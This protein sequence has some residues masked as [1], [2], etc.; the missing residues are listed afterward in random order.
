MKITFVMANWKSLAGGV[1]STG[2]LA[3]HLQKRGH[4]VY[5]VSPQKRRPSGLQQV[6][7]LLKGK[8]LIPWKRTGPSHLDNLDLPRRIL[9]HPPPVTDADIPDADIVIATWWE[10][11]ATSA[12]CGRPSSKTPSRRRRARTRTRRRSSDRRAPARPGRLAR[13]RGRRCTRR[14]DAAPTSCTGGRARR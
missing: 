13:V 2:D 7:S 8:G 6:K 3:Y 10:T 12:R 4:E 9:D 14:L 1:Q 11:A 5:M